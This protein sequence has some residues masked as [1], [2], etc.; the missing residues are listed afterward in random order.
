MTE[1]LDSRALLAALPALSRRAP[2]HQVPLQHEQ[3]DS[4][5]EEN[6]N[7]S[8]SINFREL[9]LQQRQAKL[10]ALKNQPPSNFE[11]T[12]S[13]QEVTDTNYR[14]L[15]TAEWKKR[16]LLLENR[17]FLEA[18]S[19][20]EIPFDALKRLLPDRWDL[21]RVNGRNFVEQVKVDVIH[22]S[23]E[24]L[25]VQN[26]FQSGQIRQVERNEN[27]Y[28]YLMFKLKSIDFNRLF[29]SVENHLFH[30]TNV[31]NIDPIC[32]DNFNYRLAG[33]STGVAHGRGVYFA[34]NSQTSV[35][36][37]Q[38]GRCMF[39]ARTLQGNVCGGNAGMILPLPNHD[40]TGNGSILVKYYDNQFYPEYV[41]HF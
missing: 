25:E 14:E 35:Q 3:S 22:G 41:I 27:P 8:T 12:Q 39:M 30:G 37:T 36:Y 23:Q 9:R 16:Q 28:L 31:A 40:T 15:R 10:E 11:W 17:S 7:I 2:T 26:R 29:Q 5:P 32:K 4:E 19:T 34:P 18:F 20:K 33:S 6:E 1:V 21:V 38:N 24:F 13:K